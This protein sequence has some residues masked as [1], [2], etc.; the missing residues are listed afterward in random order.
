MSPPVSP[1]S[2]SVCVSVGLLDLLH[3]SVFH[4]SVRSASSTPFFLCAETLS[5]SPDPAMHSTLVQTNCCLFFRGGGH[6]ARRLHHPT[7][8]YISQRPRDYPTEHIRQVV[9]SHVNRRNAHAQ[10]EPQENPENPPPN[11]PSTPKRGHCSRHVLR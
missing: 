1:A 4:D 10:H 8:D 7:A 5:Q 2:T 11:L 9:V 6:R 3:E